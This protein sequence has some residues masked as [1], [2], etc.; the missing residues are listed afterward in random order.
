VHTYGVLSRETIQT[1]TL[2][3]ENFEKN[4]GRQQATPTTVAEAIL[5]NSSILD[6]GT[7]QYNH[8]AQKENVNRHQNEQR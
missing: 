3:A 7:L 8:K 5:S 2:L 6:C 1:Y 4:V